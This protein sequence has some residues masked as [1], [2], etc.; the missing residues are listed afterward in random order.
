MNKWKNWPYWLRGGAVGI[1]IAL[2]SF[3]MTQ[4]CQNFIATQGSSG[5]GLECIPL[6][7]PWIPL[8][9]FPIVNFATIYFLIIGIVIWFVVGSLIGLFIAYIKSKK[10]R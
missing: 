8:W 9:F 1:I 7:I 4:L 5:F 2:I 6:A 3:G 10:Y